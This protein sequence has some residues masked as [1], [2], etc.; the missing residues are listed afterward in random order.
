MKKAFSFSIAMSLLLSTIFVIPNVFAWEI[1]RPSEHLYFYDERS[2]NSTT[3]GNAATGVG[4]HIEEYEENHPSKGDGFWLRIVGTA[5]T[6]KGVD[7]TLYD[8][9][10]AYSWV[11]IT[12]PIGSVSGDVDTFFVEW[13]SKSSDPIRFYGG[14][15]STS[16]SGKYYYLYGCRNGWL[17]L[18]YK[19]PGGDPPYPYGYYSESIPNTIE[20]N[21]FIAPFWKQ[22][23]LAAGGEIKWDVQYIWPPGYASNRWCLIISWINVPDKYDVPQT[24]QAIIEL[25][26]WNR[27]G[28]S[29]IWFQYKSITTNDP[30]TRIGIEDQGGWKGR[31]CNVGDLTNGKA[32][33]FKQNS[34]AYYIQYI[35]VKISCN[36]PDA[37]VTIDETP[38]WIRGRNVELTQGGEQEDDT[39]TYVEALGGGFTLLVDAWEFVAPGAVPILVSGAAL[40]IGGGLVVL[41]VVDYIAKHQPQADLVINNEEKWV[42]ATAP[43]NSQDPLYATAVDADICFTAYWKF[44]DHPAHDKTHSIT[45]TTELTYFAVDIGV[46]EAPDPPVYQPTLTTSTTL[47][48]VPD[49]GDNLATAKLVTP[50]NY[51]GCLDGTDTVDVYKIY[52]GSSMVLHL[53]MKLPKNTNF[54]LYLYNPSG[55]LEISSEKGTNVTEEI[56]Y[57]T[58]VGGNWSIKVSRATGY[59]IY[60]LTIDQPYPAPK[61]TV[62]TKTTGGSSI[63]GVEVYVDLDWYYSPI[64]NKPVIPG[65]HTITT[66]AYFQ[67]GDYLY[68]FQYWENG[69]TSNTRTLNIQSDKTITAFY[70]QEYN[71]PPP[72]GGCPYV[73]TW[74]GTGYVRDNNVLGMSEV[75]NGVDVEDYYKLE[76]TLVPTY[77]GRWFSQYSLQ[78][79]EF[80]HEHSY[81]DKVRLYAVDHDPNVNIAL[82]PDGQILTYS[83]PNTPISAIDNYGY[84]WL[85]FVSTPDNIYYRGF[86]GDYLLLDFGS[87]DTSQAAKLV[88][89][90]NVELKKDECIHVQVL[91]ETNE[92][93]DAAILRTRY[94]W[95][96]II[97]DLADHLPNPDGTLKMRLYFTGIHKIDYV[98]IDTT[99]QADITTIKTNAFSAIHSTHGDVTL[100]LLLNDQKY[101]ELVPGEQIELKFILPNTQKTRTFIIYT[102]G[103]YYKIQ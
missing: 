50:G 20:P 97:V 44:L 102:E 66:K 79:S 51:R 15:G 31:S 21:C 80:E 86:P 6:R 29:H 2:D 76:Q 69:A 23:N 3:D 12:S 13:C 59:G 46:P 58:T 62:L 103:H 87:I 63:S 60:N 84:D 7:Y 95:S 34:P 92:W 27:H 22:L 100:K 56:S 68:T 61:L 96:T 28:S 81:I 40:L 1:D 77:Q 47:T 16:D 39:L 78:I 19:I 89:R 88:L 53:T 35:T 10:Y 74:N 73:Y 37:D 99:A 25:M 41:G 82:T 72:G 52:V 75:S 42:K 49:V 90:A 9:S 43:H 98:G 70:K 4:V 18:D 57:P 38:E 17:W 14:P 65:T 24:F 64:N 32:L 83:N 85:P 54:N 30:G 33:C 93:T 45:I 67:I 71:P 5:N 11:E 91:N 101:A 48:V 55:T 8:S 26:A 94:H 36:D